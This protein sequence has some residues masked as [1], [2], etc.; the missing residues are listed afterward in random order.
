MVALRRLERRVER[1]GGSSPSTRTKLMCG[2]SEFES[3]HSHQIAEGVNY[4]FRTIISK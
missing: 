4:S 1:R 3:H 2:V